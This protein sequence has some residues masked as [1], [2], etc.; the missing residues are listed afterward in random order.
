MPVREGDY[1]KAGELICQLKDDT[2]QLELTATRNK[3]ESLQAAVEIAKA[4]F[5]R[6]TLEKQRVD[7]LSE[8][9]RANAKELYDTMAD[10]LIAKNRAL[11]AELA[12]AEQKTLVE[13]R[14][15]EL[16]K[17][18]VRSPFDG[19]VTELHTEL[20][21]WLQLGGA[22]VEMIDL[23][24]VLV[25]VDAPESAIHYIAV[26]DPASV[27]FDAFNKHFTGHIEHVIP[28]AHEQARTFPVEIKIPNPDHQ[29]RSGLFAR[30]TIKSGP[31]AEIIAV[32]KDAVVR[33]KGTSRIWM[34][35][36][37]GPQ[38]TMAIP[39]SVT[40]GT[41]VGEW[42]AV[43]SGNVFPGMQ[44]VIRGNEQLMPFPAP[45][46]V[47]QEEA[48]ISTSSPSHERDRIQTGRGPAQTSSH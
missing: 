2:L 19:Y 22:I 7:R 36:D 1:V 44:V 30:V 40:L 3:L 33:K 14:R 8:E 43:T 35:Q 12:V 47:V 45:V 4:D 16:A 24:S 5:D 32:P 48:L 38:G 39:M 21:Q 46:Q 17:T 11:E 31:A 6:W 25:R 34:V 13:L 29:L 28:Q 41:E 23:E 20:G 42:V 27:T 9:S 15:T 26:G 37:A 10:F 18:L